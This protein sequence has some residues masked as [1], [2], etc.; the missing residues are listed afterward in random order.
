[1]TRAG[2]AHRRPRRS[3]ASVVVKV[4]EAVD[5]VREAEHLRLLPRARTRRAP[6]RYC[7]LKPRVSLPPNHS[8]RILNARQHTQSR[9]AQ[10]SSRTHETESRRAARGVRT[11]LAGQPASPL[12]HSARRHSALSSRAACCPA[13]RAAR[14]V[15]RDHVNEQ[16][17]SRGS[18]ERRCTSLACV[19]WGPHRHCGRHAQRRAAAR[20]GGA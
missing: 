16:H 2:G 17:R 11:L 15:A 18:A 20:P 19:A 10:R 14:L 13:D 12:R 7:T 5:G 1:M 3:C 9:S 4:H 8:S 6:L